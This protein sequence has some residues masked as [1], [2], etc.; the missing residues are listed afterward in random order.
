MLL[1]KALRSRKLSLATISSVV[2]S[3]KASSKKNEKT[4]TLKYNQEDLYSR[5]ITI[6]WS[7]YIDFKNVL[8]HELALIPLVL[9]HP[10]GEMRKTNKSEILK[11][12]EIHS[13][14]YRNVQEICE[15][16]VLLV[17]NFMPSLQALSKLALKT[18]GDLVLCL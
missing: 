13:S 4:K 8:S 3:I 2:K 15:N 5:L 6:R 16:K 12:L 1:T 10:T 18:F 11:E 7:H 14:S 9:F 17:I